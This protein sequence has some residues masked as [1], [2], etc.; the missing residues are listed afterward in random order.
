M[1]D[2]RGEGGSDRAAGAGVR[3]SGRGDY[4][5]ALQRG[6][7]DDVARAVPY[8][9]EQYHLLLVDLRGH[10]KSDAPQS[11]YHMDDMAVD[12]VGMMEQLH[13]ERAH[14]VGSSLGAEVGL[15]LAANYSEKMIR[16]CAMGHWRANM[17]HMARGKAR[18]L[19]SRS[20]SASCWEKCTTG[21]IGLPISEGAG[22]KQPGGIGR[23]R[24]V[25]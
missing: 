17:G 19:S 12:V 23:N 6:K 16:W 1:K 8:F 14:I 20:T 24:L 25:E 2:I 21:R 22:G 4:L 18:R 5:P 13:L 15:S 10:G 7:L 3:A 9:Q 11:G